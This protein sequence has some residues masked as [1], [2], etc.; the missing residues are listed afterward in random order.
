M[1]SLSIEKKILLGSA[2]LVA[3][4][5]ASSGY[6]FWN[7]AR[8]EA[9]VKQ[10]A[11]AQFPL[12]MDS[13]A[14][15]FTFDESA[16][17]FNDAMMTGDAELIG[18]AVSRDDRAIES[19]K[20]IADRAAALGQDSKL[21]QGLVKDLQAHKDL[22]RAVFADLSAQD[23]QK[24]A[25]VQ[26]EAQRFA[27]LGVDLRGKLQQSA[28]QFAADL[29]AGLMQMANDT[30]EKRYVDLTI[31]GVVILLGFSSIWIVTRRSVTRPVRRVMTDLTASSM[32][33]AE[34]SGEMVEKLNEASASLDEVAE[35]A[36]SNSASVQ[37]GKSASRQT[38]QAAEQGVTSMSTMQ[39]T[40]RGVVTAV[41]DLRGAMSDVDKS[42]KAISS[43]IKTI[44]EIAFQTNLLALNAAVE[45]AR[46]GEAGL[47]FAV[48]ANEV[49]SL[50]ARS[51]V[52]AKETA[53]L[54][55][56]AI[57]STGRGADTSGRVF[58][59]VQAVIAESSKVERNLSEIATK[60]R[61]VDSLVE[62]IEQA[63]VTQ[64]TDIERISN[65]VGSLDGAKGADLEA[66]AVQVLR[67]QAS[68]L[69]ELVSTL[70]TLVNGRSETARSTASG[71]VEAMKTVYSPS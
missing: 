30:R 51:T 45:A 9:K 41:E 1:F 6:R 20:S 48:V 32:R 42:S 22:G 55:E 7:G 19:L 23:E 24:K 66:A 57:K 65:A 68:E 18:A 67:A 5:L 43:I 12:A 3:G 61:E 59:G 17:L 26:K 63:S 47:G 53:E 25:A 11:A 62:A 15:L 16:K 21:L 50:A 71:S 40:L 14:A 39:S 60:V 13:K 10:I 29:N 33:V 2:L 52:A 31:C 4:Y 64:S 49:R 36:R 44:D 28:E 35:A 58:T 56:S 54:I 70:E 27:A 37:Q 38:L 34:V 46:A 69:G 8:D